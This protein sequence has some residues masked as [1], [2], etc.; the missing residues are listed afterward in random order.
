MRGTSDRARPRPRVHNRVMS[1]QRSYAQGNGR[2]QFEFAALSADATHQGTRIGETP[3]PSAPQGAYPN[4][5]LARAAYLDIARPTRASEFWITPHGAA[6]ARRLF[7][8]VLT[9][10]D[11]RLGSDGPTLCLSHATR[12]ILERSM[13]VHVATAWAMLGM[14]T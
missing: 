2:L 1:I 12:E 11:V 6:Y 8:V 10:E 14:I 3:R 13:T 4:F 9:P 5:Y 7:G